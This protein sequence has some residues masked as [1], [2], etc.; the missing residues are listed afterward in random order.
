MVIYT[1]YAVWQIRQFEKMISGCLGTAALVAGG[2]GVYWVAPFIAALI[3]GILELLA[4]LA[5]IG[6][7][8]AILGG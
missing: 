8:L 1:I 3:V 7:I 5:V 4:V 6:I 2:V